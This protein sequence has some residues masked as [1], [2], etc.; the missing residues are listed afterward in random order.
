MQIF[1][2]GGITRGGDIF[3]ALALGA[4]AVGLGSRQCSVC[5]HMVR[6]GLCVCWRF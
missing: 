5:V 2:D 3:K 4:T 6:K 1:V